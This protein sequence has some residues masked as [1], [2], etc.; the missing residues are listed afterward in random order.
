MSERPTA[1]SGG[2]A[3]AR[4][5]ADFGAWPRRALAAGLAGAAA[6]AIGFFL[7]REQFF[8]SY[9][10]A[11]V[12]WIGI[13][14]GCL[15][16]AMLHN[17]TGGGWGSVVRRLGEAATRTLPL[18]ALLFVP[19]ALG[20]PH[21]YEWAR[22]DAVAASAALQRKSAYLN[23]PFMVVRAAIAFAVWIAFARAV[24]AA[25]AEQERA[26]ASA[27][28]RDRA[29]A[30]ASAQRIK[31]LSAV[32]ILLYVLTMTFAAIDW[33]MS[34]D[35]HWFSTIFGVILIV[36]QALSAFAFTICILALVA[37]RPPLAGVVTKTDLHDLGNLMFAFLMLWAYV[38]ISQLIIIWSANLPE[39]IPWY[40]RRFRGG[41]RAVGYALVVFHFAAPFVILLMRKAKR[42]I[43]R[44]A[45]VAAAILVMR[46]VD[47]FWTIVPE[48]HREGFSVHWM[49]A[50]A[51]VAVGGVWLGAYLKNLAARPLL[52][53]NDPNLAEREGEAA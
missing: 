30:A 50:A 33:V 23:V 46:F 44:L 4:A 52:V 28:P 45:A 48:F 1:P 39:E 19:I 12:F 20:A 37:D 18:M 15:G 10:L 43:G 29:S 34:L 5:G 53:A 27:L 6:C 22:P 49:D 36:G 24:A 2:A 35:P 51:A 3:R 9:L 25:S 14:L 21:L 40:V 38:T 41:W 13:P 31:R 32:G 17:L 8:R 7:D 16:I 11:F 47:A 42:N 26:G